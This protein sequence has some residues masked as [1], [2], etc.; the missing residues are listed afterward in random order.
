MPASYYAPKVE[1]PM[2][3]CWQMLTGQQD[4]PGNG[5]EWHAL[6]QPPPQ[7]ISLK[8]QSCSPEEWQLAEQMA[9]VVTCMIDADPSNRPSTATLIGGSTSPSER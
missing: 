5:E 2:S 9:L 6:R 1:G 7:K 3:Q 8:V 4:L